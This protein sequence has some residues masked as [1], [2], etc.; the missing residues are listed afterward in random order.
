MIAKI[1]EKAENCLTIT[2]TGENAAEALIIGAATMNEE[3]GL[4]ITLDSQA[5]LGNA[6]VGAK[7]RFSGFG[8][9]AI[10]T[11][12]ANGGTNAPAR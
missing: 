9:P 5:Y 3:T 11:L 10:D 8:V 4:G 12:Q 6:L 1:V 2:F 7:V